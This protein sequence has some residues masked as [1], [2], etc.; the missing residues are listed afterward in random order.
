MG[1][2]LLRFPLVLL[3]YGLNLLLNVLFPCDCNCA[4]CQKR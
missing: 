1:S 3:G 4:S 2:R